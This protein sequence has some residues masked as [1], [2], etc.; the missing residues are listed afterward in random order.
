MGAREG[1]SHIFPWKS[2]PA[3]QWGSLLLFEASLQQHLKDSFGGL[4]P[5][6]PT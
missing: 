4:E 1:E 2:C 5:G 6:C 3:W